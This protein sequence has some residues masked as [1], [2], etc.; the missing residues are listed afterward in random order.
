MPNI[1]GL[2]PPPPIAP[3]CRSD[4]SLWAWRVTQVSSIPSLVV[5]PPPNNQVTGNIGQ[6]VR[7]IAID[8]GHGLWQ[9]QGPWAAT[10]MMVGGKK[11][12]SDSVM[13]GILSVGTYNHSWQRCLSLDRTSCVFFVCWNGHCEPE[14]TST[15][16]TRTPIQ[17]LLYLRPGAH[18]GH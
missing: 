9:W 15:R 14:F 12:P 5:A 6:T 17:E 3:R 7:E 10:T 18:V 16:P 2:E 13:L 11:T 4:P 8:S 1:N